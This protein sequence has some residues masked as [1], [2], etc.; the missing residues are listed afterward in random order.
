VSGDETNYLQAP[1]RLS[2]VIMTAITS[3]MVLQ[4]YKRT[5]SLPYILVC[6]DLRRSSFTSFPRGDAGQLPQPLII[7]ISETLYNS[8]RLLSANHHPFV[9]ASINGKLWSS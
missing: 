3:W 1:D 2:K 6:D 7:I 4:L 5:L 8:K 9:K